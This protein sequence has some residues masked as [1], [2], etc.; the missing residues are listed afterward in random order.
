MRPLAA[1][2]TA[3]DDVE[4][5]SQWRRSCA[6]AARRAGWSR[7]ARG[8]PQG[9]LRA[10]SFLRSTE[11]SLRQE[12]AA[13][14]QGATDGLVR[15]VDRER[16]QEQFDG[17]HRRLSSLPNRASCLWPSRLMRDGWCPSLTVLPPALPAGRAETY[18][19]FVHSPIP[20]ITEPGTID[21]LLA[22]AT[23]WDYQVS[24]RFIRDWTK[25]GLLDRPRKRPA[26]RGRGSAP[27]LYSANQ[28]ML[29]L[30]LL[31]KRAEGHGIRQIA[32]I[33]VWFWMYWGDDYVPLAQ[34]R[35]AFMTWL[36]DQTSLAQAQANAREITK[37][38]AH[39]QATRQARRRFVDLI[40][41]INYTGRLGDLAELE[42]A[43]RQVFEPGATLTHRAVGSPNAPITVEAMI[44]V[45]QARAQA[46]QK[47]K[48]GKISDTAFRRAR[49][50][51]L[52][53][54]AEYARNQAALR[55]SVPQNMTSMFETTTIEDRLNN[56]CRH[57]L[58]A[59]GLEG[60]F[61]ER[62]DQMRAGYNRITPE[63]AHTR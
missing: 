25:V 8:C 42:D 32:R 2:V 24:V 50:A 36:E 7:W 29:F 58:T 55:A 56:C 17:V 49:Q 16:E 23:A 62:A 53:H 6:R 19:D 9:E 14:P 63:F 31:D 52:V 15:A 38:F 3:A 39:P 43:F 54:Y 22:D 51:H 59:I 45:A 28:R 40:T 27:A 1:S 12:F 18:A 10:A 46:A 44:Q 4:C 33:P 47:L 57:L 13:E 26:G 60:M 5:C 30:V 35:R 37:Q 20:A 34:A 11:N 48:D 61:P 41:E 21:D